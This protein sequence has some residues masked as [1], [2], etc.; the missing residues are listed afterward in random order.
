M[1]ILAASCSP[2]QKGSSQLLMLDVTRNIDLEEDAVWWR[3]ERPV[4]QTATQRRSVLLSRMCRREVTFHAS[5]SYWSVTNGMTQGDPERF[6]RAA[7]SAN[8]G[9][10]LH[11]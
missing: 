11:A 2:E 5:C 10:R 3:W 1:Y 7:D 4:M 6:Q 8:T 9:L